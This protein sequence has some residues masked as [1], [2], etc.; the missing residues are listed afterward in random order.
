METAKKTVSGSAEGLRASAHFPTTTHQSIAGCLL[1]EISVYLKAREPECRAVAAPFAVFFK[2]SG[3]ICVQP[4]IV[5]V[6]D[7]EKLDEEGCHGAPD[8]VIEIVSPAS[9]GLDY[10]QKLGIYIK[11]GVREYWIVDP[12]KKLIVAYCLEHPDVP[13]IY[14]FGD[15]IKSDIFPDLVIDSSR[16]D[17]IQYKKAANIRNS[18]DEHLVA[19]L[20][21]A[22]KKTLSE[23]GGLASLSASSA[24][25]PADL[26]E[27][28][29]TEV[30]NSARRQP[31]TRHPACPE[32]SG[33]AG[34]DAPAAM[35]D[36]AEVKSFILEHLAD[37]A[38]SGNKGQLMKAAMNALK[39]RAESKVVNEAVAELCK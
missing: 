22:V 21:A 11:E 38:A 7:E 25:I 27:D 15:I 37:L 29:I 10:G 4:D 12:E 34:G 20:A 3:K 6:Q 17:H 32:G 2:N 36:P 5:V 31:D 13:A 1:T 16:L 18:Q 23:T 19:S 14:H 9:R 28:I 35:T 33:S 26:V 30:L 8:W 39:G 24:S